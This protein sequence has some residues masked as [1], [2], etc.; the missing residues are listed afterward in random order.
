VATAIWNGAIAEG[1]DLNNIQ[2]NQQME[3]RLSIPD[4]QGTAIVNL[5]VHEAND[6]LFSGRDVSIMLA[7]FLGDEELSV[8]SFAYLTHHLIALVRK[9]ERTLTIFIHQPR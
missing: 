2:L 5:T 1:V 9:P 7:N 6:E 8:A 4:S 3:I